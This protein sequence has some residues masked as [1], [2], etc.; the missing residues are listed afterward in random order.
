ML[1]S[2]FVRIVSISVIQSHLSAKSTRFSKIVELVKKSQNAYVKEL[3]EHGKYT[4]ESHTYGINWA[5]EFTKTMMQ[6][7]YKKGKIAE[8]WHRKIVFVVQN[9]AMEYLITENGQVW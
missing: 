5:N 1:R 6:Q 2:F 3:L 7:A 4:G 8:Y 9:L